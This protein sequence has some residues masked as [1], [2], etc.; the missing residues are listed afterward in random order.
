MTPRVNS[1]SQVAFLSPVIPS[2]KT[3]ANGQHMGAIRGICLPAYPALH[4]SLV[5]GRSHCVIR[6][7]ETGTARG[8]RCH[9]WVPQRPWQTPAADADKWD[10]HRT[11][12]RVRDLRSQTLQEGRECHR[13][14]L[15]APVGCSVYLSQKG[16]EWLPAVYAGEQYRDG[17]KRTPSSRQRLAA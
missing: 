8:R 13:A 7:S 17:M 5:R 11:P 2:I 1:T 3:K 4:P 10:Y 15:E 6:T 16:A 9:S 12:A 14:D